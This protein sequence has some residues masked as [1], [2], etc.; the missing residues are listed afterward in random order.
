MRAAD[1]CEERQGR[2]ARERLGEHSLQAGRLW[3]APRE[4]WIHIRAAAGGGSRAAAATGFLKERFESVAAHGERSE[5]VVTL[6]QEAGLGERRAQPPRQV[7]LGGG[8]R[9]RVDE[10]LG[11]EHEE[12][13]QPTVPVVV[14]KRSERSKWVEAG[15][16]VR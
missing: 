12:V 11:V 15:E 9:Q 7:A 14:S 3:H 6:P 16:Q 13:E 5:L 1:P 8:E 2:H 10:S 4:R